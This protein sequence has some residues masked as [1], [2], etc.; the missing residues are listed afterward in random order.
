MQQDHAAVMG[1]EKHTPYPAVLELAADLPKPM[2]ALNRPAKRHPYRPAEFCRPD[3]VAYRFSIRIIE[4]K[5]PIPDR[6]V[7]SV[8]LKEPRW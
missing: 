3:I 1:A 7:P 5:Q 6:D 4:R 8:G 2:A